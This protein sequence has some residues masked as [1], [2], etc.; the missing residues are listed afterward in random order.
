MRFL[1]FLLLLFPLPTLAASFSD[2]SENHPQYVAL[3]SLKN[4][5]IINGYPDGSFQT[6]NTVTR[7]EA[8]KMI[9]LTAEIDIPETT[10][11]GFSDI[12]SEAWFGKYTTKAKELGIVKGYGESGQFLPNN[13]VTRAEFVK[14]LLQSLQK[15]ITETSEDFVSDI[16]KGAWY[17][18]YILTANALGLITPDREGNFFPEQKL[19]RGDSADILYQALVLRQGGEAQ[20]LLS[21]AETSLV[22]ILLNLKKNNIEAALGH[23][24]S[25]VSDTEKA[26]EFAPDDTIAQG[27]YKIALS[28][29]ELCLAYQSGRT[30]DQNAIFRH[31]SRAKQLAAEAKKK[32]ISLASLSEMIVNQVE[33]L[34]EQ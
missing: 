12:S 23:A 30:A 1:F 17:A 29:E 2:I 21:R 6:G 33:V 13:Q 14:M 34:L 4:A 25:A 10:E 8:L 16:P 24:E 3:E 5:G 31:A 26:L 27:A 20:E 9:L 22:R 7:A 32:D 18:S 28:F 19:T 15:P 11:T